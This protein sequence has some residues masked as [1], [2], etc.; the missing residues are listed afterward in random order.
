MADEIQLTVRMDWDLG[1]VEGS[2]PEG[3]CEALGIDV[4]G[5]KL[6]H[7]VQNIAITATELYTGDVGAGGIIVLVNRD[8]TNYIAVKCNGTEVFQLLPGEP[9]VARLLQPDP[10]FVADTAPC[11]LEYW[12]F[13][14]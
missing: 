12:L 6:V 14:A 2:L 11:E 1:D 3:F 10:N 9:T 4:A 7:N 8:T 13:Q 5:T